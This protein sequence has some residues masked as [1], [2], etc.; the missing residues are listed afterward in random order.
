MTVNDPGET[1]FAEQTVNEIFGTGR[2]VAA[3]N[4]LT[5]AEDFS[6]ILA[7]VP[8]ACVMMGACPPGSDPAT[9]PFNHSAEAVFDDE[10]LADGAALYAE[11][12][13]CRLAAS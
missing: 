11:L 9:A 4:P 7:Q 12:A 6:C 2:F 8:G 13:L 1:A 5:A 3:P 10:V